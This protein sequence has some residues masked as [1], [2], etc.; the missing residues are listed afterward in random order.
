MSLAEARRLL[1]IDAARAADLAAKA[2]AA[3]PH[4]VEAR[5]T[6]GAAL[7]R[8][9]DPGR[10]L[11]V[12]EPL[13]APLARSWGFHFERGGAFAALGRTGAAADA[14][15]R[16][17]ALNPQSPLARHALA[18]QLVLLDR[19]ADARA[20]Q[21]HRLPGGIG[22]HALLSVVARMLDGA[23]D[24]PE[25]LGTRFG[26]VGNDALALRFLADAALALTREPDAE[27]LLARAIALAPDGHT[28]RYHL[29][30]L[31]HRQDRDREAR[32]IV[33]RETGDPPGASWLML[34]GAI[35]LR[36]GAIDAA[37]ADHIAAL[38]RR[39]DDAR[40]WHVHGHVLRTAGRQ[41][42]AI[43]AY[44]R[45]IELAP[46][47]TEPYWSIANLKSGRLAPSDV[48][49]MEGLLDR[50]G[51]SGDARAHL[52]FALGKAC[53]DGGRDDR[54]F[55]HYAAGNRL[56]A[57]STPYDMDAHEDLVRRTIA[58]FTED[59]LSARAGTGDP[60]DDPI[61]IIGLPRSGSTLVE[62]ILASHSRI[63][64]TA[65]LPE[66][67]AI[68]RALDRAGRRADGAGDRPCPA[69]LRDLPAGRFAALGRDY[70]AR[71]RVRRNTDRPRFTDKFPGNMLHAGLIHLMLP[72][73]RI[74]DVRR[75]PRANGF[76][77]FRQNFAAGQGYSYDLASL[78]RYIRAYHALMAHFD[79]V[80]PG[81]ILRLSYERLVDDSEG[82]T[83]RLLDHCGL[84]F[85]P[86]CLRFFDN[87][88]AVHTASSEQVRRPIF[89]DAIDQWRRFEPWLGDLFEVLD[90]G[91]NDTGTSPMP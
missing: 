1:A 20:V 56:R 90:R 68:A 70:L 80:M 51:L 15:G 11:A 86:A 45:A 48:A 13:G 57:A 59:F 27:R 18:D 83:R 36:C 14:F 63:E 78:G 38:L 73:A 55:G 54:A 39:P 46:H 79:A 32:T 26:L 67:T 60:A 52:H 58:T 50:A 28:A 34:R 12:L 8:A 43:A 53:E 42:E 62:Q 88:R 7:R 84:A 31:F 74:L 49:A 85:E 33:E 40:L 5:F 9:G 37:L 64:G 19:E 6:L 23:S 77:L 30:A 69:L 16:A 82:E 22:D 17:V 24:A 44:R 4:A 76:S 65:E 75:D 41:D 10:A 87:A 72:N 81:R 3:A 35:R 2:L 71:T 25:L 66:I 91:T 61:F 21:A 47:E 29:A 89:R